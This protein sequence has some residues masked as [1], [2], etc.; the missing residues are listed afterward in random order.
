M[1]RSV[2]VVGTYRWLALSL[3]QQ[4]APKS[5]TGYPLRLSTSH[6]YLMVSLND[7][8]RELEQTLLFF[9]H[10]VYVKLIEHRYGLFLNP[11]RCHSSRC[12]IKT[13]KRKKNTLMKP[14]LEGLKTILGPFP[15]T[16][17]RRIRR[18]YH[19]ED[20]LPRMGS[21][22]LSRELLCRN[23]SI[24]ASSDTWKES[25]ALIREVT[26]GVGGESG[27][28]MRPSDIVASPTGEQ[29]DPP[30]QSPEPRFS[31]SALSSA[32]IRCARPRS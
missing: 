24:S 26:V 15:F 18:Q 10:G 4:S 31:C 9:V 16:S 22:R 12:G 5:G 8:F 27:G 17:A 3:T 28:V 6:C 11:K 25:S 7:A 29:G 1:W 23:H 20:I 32:S 2:G 19:S 14:R 13:P 21:V 30:S